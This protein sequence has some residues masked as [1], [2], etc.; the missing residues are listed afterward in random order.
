VTPDGSRW[1]IRF[2]PVLPHETG[3]ADLAG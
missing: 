3:C 2:R 1:S